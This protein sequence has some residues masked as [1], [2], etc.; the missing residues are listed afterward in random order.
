M[1]KETTL[2]VAILGVVALLGA[3]Y[4]LTKPQPSQNDISISQAATLVATV[5][6]MW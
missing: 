6:A 1:D 3:V 2:I 4:L 5:A